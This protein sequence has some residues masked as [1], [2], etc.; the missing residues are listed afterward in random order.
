MGSKTK[1]N[2][3]DVFTNKDNE[4][5]KVIQIDSY[6]KVY[7]EFKDGTVLQVTSLHAAAGVR[8][9]NSKTV[10]NVGYTGYGEYSK[11]THEKL[12]SKWAS[13]ICRGYSEKYK[14]KKPTYKDV[15]VCS[16]WHNFQNFA[17]WAVNRDDYLEEWEIDKDILI[18]SNRIYSPESC[19]FVPRIINCAIRSSALKDKTKIPFRISGGQKQYKVFITLDNSV[20]KALYFKDIE[21][22]HSAVVEFKTKRVKELAEQFKQQLNSEVYLKLSNFVFEDYMYE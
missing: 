2:V 10:F 5:Y 21:Q 8:N 7:V 16:D 3:G 6:K 20:K 1:V 22:A 4:T 14:A 19:C 17:K 13:M 12:Y 9:Y 18:A 15:S 11:T